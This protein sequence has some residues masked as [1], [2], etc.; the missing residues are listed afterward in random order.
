MLQSVA[1]MRTAWHSGGRVALRSAIGAIMLG[2]R[3]EPVVVP[4]SAAERYQHWIVER[5]GGPQPVVSPAVGSALHG[6][7]F[8]LLIPVET[9]DPVQLAHTLKALKQAQPDIKW[10]CRIG[11]GPGVDAQAIGKLAHVDGET[12]VTCTAMADGERG[13]MLAE[14]AAMATG[15]LVLV[16]DPGD[17]LAPQALA[18]LAAAHG[19]GIVHGDEDRIDGDNA[20]HS[21]FLKPEWSPELLYAFNYF[22][23][24]TALP[25]IQVERLG[26]F[27]P[28]LGIGCEWDLHLRLAAAAV[29]VARLPSILCHRPES[30]AT[31][32]IAPD[33]PQAAQ[34]RA[35]LAAHWQRQGITATVTTEP[36]GTLRSI[37]P[38]PDPPLVSIVIP[39]RDQPALLQ[40]CLRS[41]QDGMHYPRIQVIIVDSGSTDP[42]T[43]A[44][45]ARE[46]AQNR[47]EVVWLAEPF[48]YSAACNTGARAA[49]GDLL[50]FLNND[51]E[52]TTPGW[53]EELVRFAQRPGVGIVGTL[54]VYPDGRLQHAG[55]TIGMH[56]CGLLF[57]G[58]AEQEWGPIGSPMVPRTLSAIMG[59]C[60]MVRR[61]AF[62][63]I[64]G[65][66][67]TYG[68]ANSDVALCLAARAAGWRIAYTPFA[69]LVH[70]EGASRGHTNPPEDMTRTANDIRR[71]GYRQD[72]FF[73]PELDA[74]SNIPRLRI[75]SEPD[76][77]AS[78]LNSL[79][80][81]GAG[82]ANP[83][84]LDLGSDADVAEAVGLADTELFWPPSLPVAITDQWSAAR[85]CIDL[86]RRRPE[87]RVRFPDAL[88]GGAD[89][90]FGQWL[91]GSGAGCLALPV[92]ALEQIRLALAAGIAARARQT[93]L[94]ESKLVGAMAL[95]FL[96]PGRATLLRTLLGR[97]T[98]ARLRP[99]E[100]WWLALE[101][102]EDP[103][104]ALILSH[105]F[106]ASWQALF[107]DGTTVFGQE[108]F[109]AWFRATYRCEADWTQ[110]ANWPQALTAAQQIRLGWYAREYWQICHSD[111]FR[112]ETTALALL[113][114]LVV[115]AA[116]LQAAAREWLAAQPAAGLAAALVAPG[117]TVIGHFCYP[118][119]LRNS[120]ISVVRG[121]RSVPLEVL[122]RDVPVDGEH[123][124]PQHAA[125]DG[126]EPYGTT[127]VHIQPEPFFGQAF[128]R[129]GL[130][131][132]RRR[133][134]RIGYWYWE[135][136]AVPESWAGAVAEVDELWAATRFVADALRSHFR[137]PVFNL[138]PGIELPA[139]LPR[140]PEHFGIPPS[141]F[142]FLFAFHMMSVMERKNPLGLIRAFRMAFSAADPVTLVLKT[143]FGEKHPALIAELHAAANA[144]GA[145]VT[146][147]DRV[148][149][150]DETISLMQACDAYVSLHRSE[151]LGLTMAEAMLLG[152]PVIATGY[153]G[154]LD[155][156]TP[157]NSLLAAY[158]LVEI[159]RPT[160]PYATG[161]LWAEPVESH[162]AQLM[163]RVWQNPDF[164]A[165]LG[166]RAKADIA[167][168]LSIAAAGRRMADRLAAIDARG[169]GDP[170]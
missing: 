120:A 102:A 114:W 44:L 162:A 116:G 143:S 154:N 80:R 145:K 91:A 2:D 148:F 130:N 101:C 95:A 121:L 127:L 76:N 147:I 107:P 6:I 47:I 122:V 53:L 56:L 125:H 89:G 58:A 93:V 128:A 57:R 51:I 161:S 103:A 25:R 40:T 133:S 150:N 139:F 82:L 41:I 18:M 12:R 156:M 108:R 105:R 39:N 140:G 115:P 24:P 151:G 94:T 59:A 169:L 14:L 38:I 55:V 87:L 160:P 21:P 167:A 84:P 112:N 123:D 113:D 27:T 10:E 37:W 119:G 13:A 22:G 50:L 67:E 138:M 170:R 78:L 164:A 117:L 48:N 168:N 32:R 20:R 132:R 137:T 1:A 149:T 70:H 66:D 3:R 97:D 72:P 155:F 153:S 61:E 45:Y 28:G 77:A 141:R 118:S 60:Q 92:A 96:P 64:G 126:P 31:D 110:P 43:L 42:E 111:P 158:R 16:L 29:P 8:S 73:H 34:H 124:Q 100:V 71:F 144:A 134:Y 46:Q 146:I 33:R 104:G 106:N 35:V 68:L 4:T 5:E 90:A 52:V 69:R 152:K 85:W 75:G 131:P 19:G 9:L 26:G 15:D 74:D 136:E 86:L 17:R 30:N 99:E 49:R 129:A 98:A 79:Q 81:H 65:F 163:R 36:D 165:A 135:L 157:E 23:R 54:L 109:A 83:V 166:R 62:A 63:Q 7:R 88:S 11:Y 142:T 159:D